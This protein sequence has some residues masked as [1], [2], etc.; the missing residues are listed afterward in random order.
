MTLGVDI[1]RYQ[2]VTDWRRFAESVRYAWVK[3]TDGNGPA[4]VRG[5]RQVNGCK[6]V[7]VPVGGYHWAQPG[8]PAHQAQVFIGE[9]RRLG[10]LD[11][12]PA[13]D[14]E[15]EKFSLTAA[16]DF[17]IKFCHE[18]ARAGYRPA[19]YLSASWAGSLRPDQWGIPGLVI[20]VAAYG[21]NDG[22][23]RE[24]SV[25]RYYRGRYD[26]HQYTSRGRVPGVSGDVD[27]NWAPAG[28][29]INRKD[30]DMPTLREMLDEK[31]GEDGLT[32]FEDWK[33]KPG[34]AGHALRFLRQNSHATRQ[35]VTSYGAALDAMAKL[36]AADDTN[37][38]TEDQV[39]AAVR[40]E[41]DAS[42]TRVLAAI[43]SDASEVNV[44]ELADALRG[45]LGD[46]VA[47]AVGRRLLGQAPTA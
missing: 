13:L 23:R 16:R 29:P 31:V 27:L 6:S 46:A 42:E 28:V 3:L 33:D 36:I 4:V 34:T 8:D 45:Q 35:I 10:A 47:E 24:E 17:G 44:A 22:Q 9:L 19:V 15:D 41:I 12:A 5:D 18:I 25:T 40:E 7:K 11:L 39:R 2:T 20:W 32:A 26:V 38:L 21:V 14:L 43:A 1:Y 30:D 37:D